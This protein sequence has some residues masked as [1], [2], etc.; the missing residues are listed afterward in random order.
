M[1]NYLGPILLYTF[2]TGI[3]VAL[4]AVPSC[5]SVNCADPNNARNATCIAEQALTDCTGL[6]V[7]SVTAPAS[8]TVRGHIEGARA[9]DGTINWS[10]IE[11]QLENDV[12]KFG[13]CVLANVFSDLIYGVPTSGSG[14]AVAGPGSAAPLPTAGAQAEFTRLRAKIFPGRTF[15]TAGGVL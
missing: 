14:S 7:T 2:I 3:C 8:T 10:S 12:I 4:A 13:G 1:R 5:S 11:T 6:D 9:L 15:K